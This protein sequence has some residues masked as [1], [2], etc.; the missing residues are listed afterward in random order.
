MKVYEYHAVHVGPDGF[1][2]VASSLGKKGWRLVDS[3]RGFP[4]LGG[5]ERFLFTFERE[6]GWEERQAR[7]AELDQWESGQFDL[8]QELA[9]NI[10]EGLKDGLSAPRTWKWAPET[11]FATYGHLLDAMRRLRREPCVKSEVTGP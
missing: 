8:L 11:Q 2:G 4:T 5:N 9:G 3:I 7:E 10:S 1:D 6:L